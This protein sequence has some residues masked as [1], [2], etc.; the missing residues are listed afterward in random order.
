MIELFESGLLWSY[1][2]AVCHTEI[3]QFSIFLTF[4]HLFPFLSVSLSRSFFPYFEMHGEK[5]WCEAVQIINCWSKYFESI[6]DDRIRWVNTF[7]S[8]F[9]FCGMWWDG[10]YVWDYVMYAFHFL[11][12]ILL[13][14]KKFS[15][16]FFLECSDI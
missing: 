3:Y 13:H 16:H 6:F 15:W 14:T 10:S 9:I 11:L 5:I 8:K 2:S 7:F 12:C 4:L 1:T